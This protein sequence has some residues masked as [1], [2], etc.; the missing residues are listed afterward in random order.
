V[1]CEKVEKQ[2]QQLS[3]ELSSA[4]LIIQMLEKESRSEDATT[5][6]NQHEERDTT[7]DWEVKLPKGNKGSPEGKKK[8]RI[9]EGIRSKTEIV[10]MKNHFLVLAMEKEMQINK[11]KKAN[12][13]NLSRSITNVPEIQTKQYK[14]VFTDAKSPQKVQQEHG[15]SP[16]NLYSKSVISQQKVIKGMGKKYKIPTISNGRVSSE[17]TAVTLGQGSTSPR[18]KESDTSKQHVLQT[19]IQN[20]ILLLGDSHIKGLAERMSISLGSSFNVTEITKPNANIK[21]ITSPSDSPPVNLTK[22]DMIIFCG[23]TRDISRNESKS[24]LHTLQEFAERTST[25]N[26]ILLEAPTRYDLPLS[27]CVNTAVKLFNK[28][29]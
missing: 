22:Q 3:D 25:T 20:K 11:N 9:T 16:L 15:R 14:C 13:D 12:S 5:T 1:K 28:R 17:A 21:G 6:L 23:G 29:M 24:G 7:G 10:E 8:T 18:G 19:H 27:S 2:L 26:V 4:Y